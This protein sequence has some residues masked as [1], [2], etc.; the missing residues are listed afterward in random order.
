LQGYQGSAGAQGHQGYQGISGEQGPQGPIGPEGLTWLGEWTTTTEYLINDAVY[1]EGNSYVCIFSHTAS[2]L[3]VPPNETYWTMLS[4]EGAQ[5]TQGP[6]GL[7]GEQGA[8]DHKAYKVKKVH[9]VH[10]VLKD[11][12]AKLAIQERLDQLVRKAI[13]VIPVQSVR[14][15]WLV[16]RDL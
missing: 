14:K 15:D 16:V 2:A 12:K 4:Q 8:A 1:Y 9:K 3:N 10:K 5:G 13:K 11:S 7:A 6:Q